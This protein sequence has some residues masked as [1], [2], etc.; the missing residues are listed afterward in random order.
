M[1]TQF[2]NRR[3]LIIPIEL[4]E[5][6]NFNQ[7]LESSPETLRFSVDGTKTFIKYDIKEILEDENYTFIDPETNEEKTYTINAGIYGR[8]DIYKEGDVEYTHEQILEILS[9]DEW[10]N[11]INTIE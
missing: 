4:I 2:P 7:V 11:P 9:T 6:I 1:S 10:T 5:S 3:W 8:P